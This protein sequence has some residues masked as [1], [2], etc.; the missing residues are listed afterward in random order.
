MGGFDKKI[1]LYGEDV[2]LS[3]RMKPFCPSLILVPE[4]EVIHLG[5]PILKD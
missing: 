2:D 4:A 1:F 3:I 5:G